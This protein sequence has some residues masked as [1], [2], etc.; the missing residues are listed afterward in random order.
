MEISIYFEFFGVKSRERMGKKKETA[1]V[2]DL[3]QRFKRKGKDKC[4]AVTGEGKGSVL[5]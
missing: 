4:R 3:S 1:G 2:E 5:F